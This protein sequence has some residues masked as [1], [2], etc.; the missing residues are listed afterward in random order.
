MLYPQLGQGRLATNMSYH[1]SGAWICHTGKVRK[2]NEDSCLFG[3]TFCGASISAP[4]RSRHSDDNWVIALADGIGGHRGGAYASRLVTEGLGKCHETTPSGVSQALQ[5]LNKNLYQVGIEKPEYSGSGAAVVGMFAGES[6]LYAFNVGDARL[7]KLEDTHLRQ[8]TQDDSVE[9]MLIAEGVIQAHD[10]I[11]P[12]NMHALTQSVGGAHEY[13]PLE[14]HFHPLPVTHRSRFLLC[15]DGLSDM[16]SHKEMESLIRPKS[17]TTAAVQALFST[18]MEAGGRDNITIAV[19]DV[20][21]TEA[22]GRNGH[23]RQ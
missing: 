18:A 2:A 13:I 19:V 17:G 22:P 23:G 9:Q 15:T 1:V 20:E 4:V 5:A 10:G 11:R 7:Y 8:I 12:S 3:G 16:V 21:K 6:G 14:P